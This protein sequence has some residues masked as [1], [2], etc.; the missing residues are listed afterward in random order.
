[1]PSRAMPSGTGG[2]AFSSSE[3][4]SSRRWI[5]VIRQM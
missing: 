1:M 4:S 5:G 3:P 2:G